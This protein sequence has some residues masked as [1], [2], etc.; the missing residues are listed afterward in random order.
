MN[1][2]IIGAS[3]GVGRCLVEQALAEGHQVTAAVRNPASMNRTHERLHVLTCNVM[4]ET[5][6]CQALEGQD[7]VFCTL[8]D[9]SRGQRRYIQ[10]AR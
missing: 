9:K 10:K 1:V 3:G 6:V 8:G 5:S 2:V 7:V 4:D